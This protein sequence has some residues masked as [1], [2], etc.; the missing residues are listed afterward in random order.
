MA[1]LDSSGM[2]TSATL[3]LLSPPKT[4][5]Y[6]VSL[7]AFCEVAEGGKL[8][9]ATVHFLDSVGVLHDINAATTAGGTTV[10]CGTLGN[11]G[12]A[13]VTI[14]AQAG[15]S[16]IQIVANVPAATGDFTTGNFHVLAAAEQLF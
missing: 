15:A 16:N 9:S 6:R 7:Y 12:Q 2:M 8:F 10:D 5:M 4:G 11:F 3:N 14:Y 1:K 13:T